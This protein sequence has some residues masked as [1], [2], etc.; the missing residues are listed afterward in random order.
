MTIEPDTKDWT[1]VLERRCGECGFNAQGVR[2]EDVGALIQ[3]SAHDWVGALRRAN[4]ARRPRDDRWS[5]LEYAC[6]VRDV[7]QLFTERLDLMLTEEEPRFA[8]WDQNLAAVTNRYDEQEPTAVAQA[9]R[10][11]ASALADRFDSLTVGE[12][13][14]TGTRSDGAH[15]TVDSFARYLLHDVRHHLH[16]IGAAERPRERLT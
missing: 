3:R 12:W 7:L 5:T 15:F 2:R 8:N 11:A 9:I 6:H 16:D 14:R 13:R 4:V 10:H 1:W